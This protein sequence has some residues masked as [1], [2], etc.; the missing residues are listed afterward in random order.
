MAVADNQSSRE[1]REEQIATAYREGYGENP[2][3]EDENLML[4][5]ATALA[6]DLPS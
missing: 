1:A 5:A 2:L 4:D 6:A 3:T